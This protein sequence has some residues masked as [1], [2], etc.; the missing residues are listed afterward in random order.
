MYQVFLGQTV[1]QV[2]DVR[3]VLAVFPSILS[4]NEEIFDSL[5]GQTRSI[6][7][8]VEVA[9][10]EQM[11]SQEEAALHSLGLKMSI[12]WFHPH[13]EPGEL[14]AKQEQK[15]REAEARRKAEL[16]E[17][18][19]ER[20]YYLCY[21]RQEESLLGSG[22]ITVRFVHPVSFPPDQ[23]EQ[24]DKRAKELEQER[25][26]RGDM[27]LVVVARLAASEDAAK[28]EEFLDD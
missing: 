14:D 22:R 27:N 2:E 13:W 23:K 1:L 12:E 10:Y 9:G 17:N 6:R 4:L 28:A 7:A 11:T 19:P 16:E 8:Y 24:A 21:F 5:A 15:Q 20:R 25:Y 18:Y 3:K 26:A